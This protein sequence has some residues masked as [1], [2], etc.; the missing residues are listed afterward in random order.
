VGIA[1]A[2][3]VAI[4]DQVTRVAEEVDDLHVAGP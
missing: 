4:A 2:I 1:D 3:A